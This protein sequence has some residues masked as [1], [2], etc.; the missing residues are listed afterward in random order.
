MA[1]GPYYVFY[2]IFLKD[3]HY[4]G[5][6]TG[7]LW[8]L[9]V[10]AEIVLFLLMQ[11]LLRRFSLRGILLV[12]IALSI[13]RW[14]LIAG[15]A[16]HFVVLLAAQL[17]HAASFGATHVVA[18]H[19]VDFYFGHRHQ[20]KGQALYSSLSFGLGGMLGSLY[21]GYFW[22]LLGPQFVYTLAAGCCVLAFTIT[23]VWIGRRPGQM[24][25]SN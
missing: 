19:L 6:L 22:E 9:G 8:S 18:I 4:S 20:G 11:R 21:S 5:T 10:F 13:V 24:V 16:D 14:L 7:L 3:Y 2:S 15:Y 12:S 25:A 1:H 17:L 23:Y